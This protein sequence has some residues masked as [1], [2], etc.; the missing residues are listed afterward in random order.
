MGV[1]QEKPLQIYNIFFKICIVLTKLP[2]K[3]CYYNNFSEDL[4]GGG[5]WILHALIIATALFEMLQ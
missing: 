1:F 3:Y 5:Q 2:L 4:W